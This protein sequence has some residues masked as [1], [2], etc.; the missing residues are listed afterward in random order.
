MDALGQ[1]R[2]G[3]RRSPRVDELAQRLDWHPGGPADVHDLELPG[4]DQLMHSA[5]P[6]RQRF[7]RLSDRHQQ[8]PML[9]VVDRHAGA[10]RI[11]G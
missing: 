1:F 4:A 11:E 5:P 3:G 9:H 10:M 8:P 2:L 6:D 7:R